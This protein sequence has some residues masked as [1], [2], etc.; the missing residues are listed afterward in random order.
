[1]TAAAEAILGRVDGADALDSLDWAPTRLADEDDRVMAAA[2]F[3]AAGRTRAVTPAL[4]RLA[5]AAIDGAPAGA[6]IAAIDAGW[7]RDSVRLELP[8]VE[9]VRITGPFGLTDSPVAI[10]IA[11][12]ELLIGSSPV[13]APSAGAF[14]AAILQVAWMPAD[15][16]V[17]AGPADAALAISRVHRATRFAVANEILGACDATMQLARTYSADRKQFGSPIGRFQAVQHVLAEA[18]SQRLALETACRAA[19][20]TGVDGSGSVSAGPALDGALLKALAGRVGRV[21]MQ[22]TL[23]VLGAIGF[24]E[25][26]VHHRFLRRVLTL[27]AMFGSAMSLTRALGTSAIAARSVWQCAVLTAG[28]ESTNDI[29]KRS[30]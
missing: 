15:A 18:E 3:R 26:H 14:D 10:V 27:D 8:T 11:G 19:V 7:N 9:R 4:S 17:T 28:D 6:A 24:T 1:M 22:S 12:D 21:V 20:R 30:R 29:H 13:S 2:L 16:V 25:E 5:V 23:Q